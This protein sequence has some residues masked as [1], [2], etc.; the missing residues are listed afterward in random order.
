M[1]F[2]LHQQLEEVKNLPI[3][4]IGIYIDNISVMDRMWLKANFQIFNSEF[5]FL[6]LVWLPNQGKRTQYAI[7]FTHSWGELYSCLSEEH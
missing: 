5:S 1:A 4:L 3:N 2:N 7:L 6:L